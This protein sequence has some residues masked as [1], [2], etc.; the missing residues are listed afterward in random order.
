MIRAGLASVTFRRFSPAE[1]VKAAANAGLHAVEWAGDTHV[2]PGAIGAARQ[3][4]DITLSAGMEVASY[5]SYYVAGDDRPTPNEF[6]QVLDTAVAL[7]ASNIRVWA[8]R[9][10]GSSATEAQKM[11]VVEDLRRICDLA[12]GDGIR[13]STEFHADTLTSTADQTCWL[14]DQ[15]AHPN[16]RT[17]WQP[18]NGKSADECAADLE[19]VSSHLENLHVFHWLGAKPE[20]R[21]LS[22]GESIWRHYLALAARASGCRFAL[23][24]FVAGDA[25]DAFS[26]DARALRA[27][28][29]D[30]PH[31]SKT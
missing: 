19:K 20:R 16:L 11:M 7:G 21:P 23:L 12:G 22:D 31:D 8:G 3:V 10:D 18:A 6:A 30:F 26:G 14:L 2:Q 29:S 24:E 25:L 27:W 15:V 1:V 9:V 13:I 17:Y 4:R 28:L 5:G